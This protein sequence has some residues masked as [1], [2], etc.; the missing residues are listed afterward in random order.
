MIA[1]TLDAALGIDAPSEEVITGV[2][3][4]VQP[5]LEYLGTIA[6]AIS[7]ALV[8]GRKRMDI[9]GVVVLGAIVAVGGGTIRDVLLDREV[10]WVVDPAFLAVGVITALLSIP[11]FHIASVRLKRVYW[12]VQAFDAFGM[13]LFVVAGTNIAIDAGANQV[14]AAAI[15]VISGIGGGIIRDV[16]ATEIPT[17]MVGGRLYLTAALAGAIV[18]LGL[19][20]FEIAAVYVLWIPIIVIL[21]LRYVSLRFGIG[22]P[23]FAIERDDDPE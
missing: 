9:S 13:A 19:L 4:T 2:L 10:F 21:T 7:G 22:L 15:G 20:Q 17:V 3:D 14:A 8:A 1:N 5:I 6:F 11:V 16:L 12:L 23:T 18:Y